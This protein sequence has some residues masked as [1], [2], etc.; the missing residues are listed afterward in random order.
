MARG[1][2]AGLSRRSAVAA[3]GAVRARACSRMSS[4]VT[5][6]SMCTCG[7]MSR[8]LRM[9]SATSSGWLVT[10]AMCDMPHWNSLSSSSRG[11]SGETGSG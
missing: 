1:A 7:G 4:S 10:I 3:R 6:P 8:P 2:A 11:V 5:M 9:H